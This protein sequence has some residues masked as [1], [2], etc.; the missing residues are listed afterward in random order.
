MR[1]PGRPTREWAV[2]R[3]E[4]GGVGAIQQT[5]HFTEY[6]THEKVPLVEQPSPT[7]FFIHIPKTGGTTLRALLFL[8]YPVDRILSVYGNY[9]E[10]NQLLADSIPRHRTWALVQGHVYYGAHY[11]LNI[12]NPSYFVFLRNPVDRML[13]DI[14]HILRKPAHVFHNRLGGGNASLAQA[15][16]RAKTHPYYINTMTNYMS[17]LNFSRKAD[18]SDLHRAIDNL[19]HCRAIGLFERYEESLLLMAKQLRWSRVVSEKL[20][21]SQEQ[22]ED[23]LPLR[24]SAAEVLKLDHALYAVARDIAEEQIRTQGAILHEAAEQLREVYRTLRQSPL[25]REHEE[26][27]IHVPVDRP[28]KDLGADVPAK[29]PLGI[30]LRSIPTN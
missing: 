19:W 5:P 12:R 15:V 24:R 13:S 23:S 11:Q 22:R 16:E 27:E 25:C 6:S 1:K 9:F 18:L 21:V 28:P 10:T 3:V 20:N 7:P 14:S 2:R 26:F 4:R 29:S 8:N 30:W 17:G